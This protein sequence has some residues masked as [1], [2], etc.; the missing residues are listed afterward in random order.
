MAE[1]KKGIDLILLYRI[2][3]KATEEAAWKMAFQTEHENSKS[4]SADVTPTKDGGIIALG[5]I[6]YTLTGTSIA[7]KGDS[8]IDELDNAFDNG[9][10]IEVWEIDKAERGTA[11]N[12]EKYKAKYAQAYLTSFGWTPGAEDALELSLEFGVFG[13]QQK[14]Y[15]TLT[16]DQ[17]QVVQYVFTD[18]VKATPEG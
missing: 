9:E 13:R 7:A 18:T 6:E 2:K 1:A 10:V 3:S 4:R 8:H 17:A 11:E 15:A 16:E 5:D 12:A 14:G